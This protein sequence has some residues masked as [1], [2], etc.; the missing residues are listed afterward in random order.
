[1]S[2]A[3]GTVQGINKTTDPSR[4][5]EFQTGTVIG[6]GWAVG[7]VIWLILY[8]AFFRDATKKRKWLVFAVISLAS[9]VGAMIGSQLQ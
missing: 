6:A 8:F 5:I 9:M 4:T 3:F 1:M 2:Y 7:I